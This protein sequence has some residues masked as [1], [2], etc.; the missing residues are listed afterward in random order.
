[1]AWKI[2]LSDRAEKQLRKLDKPIARRI[3]GFLKKKVEKDPKSVGKYLKAN[4]SDL[5]SY[6]VGDYR[7]VCSFEDDRLLVLVLEIGHRR[8]AYR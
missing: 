4:L 7:L 2:E 3:L 5:W 1:M 6:R 8:D